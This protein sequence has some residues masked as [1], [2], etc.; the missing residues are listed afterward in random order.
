MRKAEH[1]ANKLANAA[2]KEQKDKEWA[3]KKER[4]EGDRAGKEGTVDQL[5]QG[6]DGLKVDG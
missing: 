6:T 5:V 3:E 4:E 2:K 1:D